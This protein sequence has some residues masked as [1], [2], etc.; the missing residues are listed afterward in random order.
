MEF[1]NISF[2]QKF[3]NNKLIIWYKNPFEKHLFTYGDVIEASKKIQAILNDEFQVGK[4]DKI[5]I[6]FDHCPQILPVILGYV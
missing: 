6:S 4:Y 1:L 5:A 2:L 3:S